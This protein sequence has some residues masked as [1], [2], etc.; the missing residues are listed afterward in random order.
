[1][2]RLKALTVN[3]VD[4]TVR[5][6][7]N[8]PFCPLSS[9]FLENSPATYYMCLVARVYE[10]DRRQQKHPVPPRSLVKI[11]FLEIF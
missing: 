9:D 2:I 4:K 3:T 10:A 5:H 8:L 1:M 7:R 6:S 11:D